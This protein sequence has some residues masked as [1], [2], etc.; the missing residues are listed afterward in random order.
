MTW[1]P[2]GGPKSRR[3]TA[4]RP[5]TLRENYIDEVTAR[6]AARSKLDAL[7]RWIA[8]RV[9]HEISSSGADRGVKY[10]R[11]EGQKIPQKIPDK[12]ARGQPLRPLACAPKNTRKITAGRVLQ[13]KRDFVAS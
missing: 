4:S 5:Y 11:V 12:S 7:G 6:P 2:R 10:S 8:T 1:K 3:E 9:T 13:V